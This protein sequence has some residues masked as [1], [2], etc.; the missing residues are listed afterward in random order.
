MNWTPL[1]V[2]CKQS[3][4]TTFVMWLIRCVQ[5]I[6]IRNTLVQTCSAWWLDAKLIIERLE[7]KIFQIT[8]QFQLTELTHICVSEA[9]TLSPSHYLNQCR[10]IVTRTLRNQ[11]KEII[12]IHIFIHENAS[13][14][15]VCE[16]AIIFSGGGG[17]GG[18]G[19]IGGVGVA[20]CG[21]EWG[22]WNSCHLHWQ[23]IFR[24]WQID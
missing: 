1:N 18:G 9:G 8:N 17:V 11:F 16:M 3:W 6:V 20:G 24:R 5:I 14:N 23:S 2:K 19:V 7:W 15:I 22:W 4:F 21:R 12:N 13:A 10:V